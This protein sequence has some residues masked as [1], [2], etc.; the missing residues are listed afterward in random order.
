MLEEGDP[1]ILQGNFGRE[2]PYRY[3][4]HPVVVPKCRYLGTYLYAGGGGIESLT[5]TEDPG[6]PGD[7]LQLD[8][9]KVNS[10]AGSTDVPPSS[11]DILPTSTSLLLSVTPGCAP[12]S[13]YKHL[14]TCFAA[15]SSTPFALF[16]SGCQSKVRFAL[17]V[18]ESSAVSSPR[19]VLLYSAPFVLRFSA[20]GPV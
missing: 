12:C 4:R 10:S 6:K 11:R 15:G 19:L 17:L 13:W 1:E 5:A 18:V 14:L 8:L 2:K 7:P 9:P 20:P 16:S 3:R